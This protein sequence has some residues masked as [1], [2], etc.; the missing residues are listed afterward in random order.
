MLPPALWE[1]QPRMTWLFSKVPSLHT[2]HVCIRQFPN[3]YI[4]V[5][6]VFCT[7]CFILWKS[8]SHSAGDVMK[9]EN[10]THFLSHSSGDGMKCTKADHFLSHANRGSLNLV[11]YKT[12]CSTIVDGNIWRDILLKHKYWDGNGSQ[13]KYMD[14]YLIHTSS[15][16]YTT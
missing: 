7:P 13:G 3:K 10:D 11:W 6:A 16:K 9:L 2:G 15:T 1:A 14:T 4:L 5:E 12:I 8:L